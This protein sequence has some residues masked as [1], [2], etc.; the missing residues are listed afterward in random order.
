MSDLTP[1]PP[2]IQE[3]LDAELSEAAAIAAINNRRAKYWMT[4]LALVNRVAALRRYIEKI[5]R[6][7]IEFLRKGP[8]SAEA[9]AALK[10]LSRE[11]AE[12]AFKLADRD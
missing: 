12:L 11:A 2:I 3:M 7:D 1:L 9:I 10:G 5:N 4:N 8:N 6:E